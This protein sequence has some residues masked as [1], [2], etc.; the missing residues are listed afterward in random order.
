MP[1]AQICTPTLVIT[2]SVDSDASWSAK[3]SKE[4]SFKRGREA[5][6]AGETGG[7]GEDG[8]KKKAKDEYWWFGY[9]LHLLVDA[10]HEVPIAAILTTAKVADTTQLKPLLEKQDALLPD[11]ALELCDGGYDSKANIEAITG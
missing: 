3:S 4:A 5:G 9:K 1:T 8:N 10:K 2:K 7:D 6:P 11:I